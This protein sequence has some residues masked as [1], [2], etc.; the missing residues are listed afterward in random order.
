MKLTEDN[1]KDI[2][3]FVVDNYLY[4]GSWR[5][6]LPHELYLLQDIMEI[7]ETD[8]LYLDTKSKE[9]LLLLTD[10][11]YTRIFRCNT[12]EDSLKGCQRDSVESLLEHLPCTI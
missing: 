12:I 2:R 7:E 9:I 3:R 11:R 4:S 6:I 8:S 10:L 5:A 1:R